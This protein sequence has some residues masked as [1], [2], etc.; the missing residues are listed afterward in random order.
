MNS[1]SIGR[2]LLGL[3]MGLG[4]ALQAQSLQ[5]Y[6]RD[7]A[8]RKPVAD[9]FVFVGNSGIGT[10]TDQD[11]SFE[12]D[13]QPY[14]GLQLFF[15]HLNYQTLGFIHDSDQSVL[16]DTI[17]VQA[18]AVLLEE[19]V[20]AAKSSPALRKRRLR[21]FKDALLGEVSPKQVKL[22]NPEVLLFKEENGLL[23]ATAREPLQ[24]MNQ[25]LGYQITF[26]LTDFAAQVGTYIRYEGTA[27]FTSLEGSRRQ[28]ARSRK[29]RRKVY[30]RS[31]RK[32]FVDLAAGNRIDYGIGRSQ[33]KEEDNY[34]YDYA[35]LDSLDLT[36][37]TSGTYVLK[38]NGFL[39]ITNYRGEADS[40]KVERSNANADVTFKSARYAKGNV[41]HLYPRKSLIRFTEKGHVLNQSEVEEYGYWSSIRLGSLL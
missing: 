20:V 4:T 11:G 23:S 14:A 9:V 29:N 8:S 13:I 3:F 5:G 17:Y 36:Q 1:R 34:F 12:L 35:A 24:I 19:A 27:F 31:S 16:E 38:H 6:V 41:S 37:D 21:V 28:L 30:I 26:F 33:K 32:F 18:Q 10:V 22:V 40:Q 15:T 7:M 25:H 2:V 39:T